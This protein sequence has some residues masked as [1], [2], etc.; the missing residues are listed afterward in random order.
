MGVGVL[1]NAA[2]VVV[3]LSGVDVM[4]FSVALF[5][6]GVGWNFLFTGGT[7][8]SMQAY[9]PHEKDRA[10]AVINFAVFAVMA[11]TS[12]ASGA[13]VTTRGWFWLNALSLLP[14]GATGLML[15]WLHVRSPQAV[16]APISGT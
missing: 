1:L 2:C 6:L 11:L 9:A 12:F 3:A 8:L 5:L 7:S 16:P 4:Q 14:L 10:Q 13:L 15:W